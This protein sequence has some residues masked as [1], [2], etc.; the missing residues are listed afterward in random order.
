MATEIWSDLH[1]TLTTD[2]Q[3]AIRKA[4]N[5]DSV[6]T[7]LDNILRT[8]KGER[9]MLPM[10]GCG[11]SDFLFEEMNE[12][13]FDMITDIINDEIKKWDNRVIL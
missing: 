5:L 2:S 11:L 7:S 9:V 10:F 4:V 12:A 1:H 8:A 13:T 3:G 6:K